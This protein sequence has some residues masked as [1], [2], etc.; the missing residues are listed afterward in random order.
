MW[1]D[2][3]VEKTRREREEYAARFNYDLEAIHKDL[4]RQEEEGKRKVVSLP[5]K[6][7][8]LIPRAKAS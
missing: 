4:K 8:E 5:P 1:Q 2:E 6:E 7:P 3:I